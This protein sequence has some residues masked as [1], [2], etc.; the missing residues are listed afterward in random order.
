M[1]KAKKSSTLVQRMFVS[2]SEWD[3]LKAIEKKHEGAGAAAGSVAAAQL[4]GQGAVHSASSFLVPPNSLVPPGASLPG[5][6][7]LK[8]SSPL[9]I[10]TDR[11]PPPEI[12]NPIYGK[13]P[14]NSDRIRA[15]TLRDKT[16]PS[17]IPLNDPMGIRDPE[18]PDGEAPRTQFIATP[19]QRRQ[20]S[21][22]SLGPV[23]TSAKVA[24]SR[25]RVEA[26]G[27]PWYFIGLD[28]SSGS[29]DEEEWDI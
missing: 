14:D 27:K 1:P 4:D 21:A 22:T 7:A 6:Q 18:V 3:R 16:L 10:E 19:E 2:V 20:D 17:S 28:F 26:L 5:L 8:D 25:A 13:I 11:L 29:E 12:P 15:E 23:M 9:R 24:A